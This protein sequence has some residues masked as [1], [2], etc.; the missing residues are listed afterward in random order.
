MQWAGLRSGMFTSLE[1]APGGMVFSD[2]LWASGLL[3]LSV[4][5]AA[6]YLLSSRNVG[7]GECI[8]PLRAPL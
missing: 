5:L 7:L 2:A 8:P 1:A 4:A 3:L 6:A